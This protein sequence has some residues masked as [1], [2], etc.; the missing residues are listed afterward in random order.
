[1]VTDGPPSNDTLSMTSG[2]KVPCA[3]NSAFSIFCASASKT[4]MNV[5]PIIFRFFSGSSTPAS[6]P[7]KTYA[8]HQFRWW[9]FESPAC[10]GVLLLPTQ[11]ALYGICA[12]RLLEEPN[13]DLT[14]LAKLADGYSLYRQTDL[15]E[16]RGASLFG[17]YSG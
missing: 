9:I 5:A 12:R 2:Y 14:K 17:K 16:T 3:R 13:A 8:Y 10:V 1:M 6:L 15:S 4:S 11:S 7:R